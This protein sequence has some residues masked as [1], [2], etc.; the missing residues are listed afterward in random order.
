MPWRPISVTAP[1]GAQGRFTKC[2]AL[3]LASDLALLA[4]PGLRGEFTLL[5]R[6]WE[7]AKDLLKNKCSSH[8]ALCKLM[9]ALQ[10]EMMQI[11]IRNMHSAS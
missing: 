1:T 5:A 9:T 4:A 2:L 6:E 10:F 8:V 3:C 7:L 11:L